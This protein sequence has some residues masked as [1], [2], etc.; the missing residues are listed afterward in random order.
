M[1]DLCVELL[2]LWIRRGR[3]T[4]GFSFNNESFGSF[5][6]VRYHVRDMTLGDV[7]L[8]AGVKDLAEQGLTCAAGGR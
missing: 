1:V 5:S 4:E 3:R 7:V 6:E 8:C 2:Y